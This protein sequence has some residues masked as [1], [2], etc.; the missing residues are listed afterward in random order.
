MK[1]TVKV[2]ATGGGAHMYYD[3]LVSELGVEVRREEE[4][5]CL[6]LGLGFVAHVPEEVFW[7][8]EELVY[9]VSHPSS[10]SSSAIIPPQTIP[11]SELPRPSP[12]PPAYQ[13]TFAPTPSSSDIGG[14]VAPHFPCLLVNIGSGV[15]IVK[16]DEDGGFERVSGTSLGGGTL[17]GLLSLLTDAQ[18]FDGELRL[19]FVSHH[20]ILPRCI[21]PLL[22]LLPSSRPDPLCA[23]R[24]CISPGDFCSTICFHQVLIPLP[25]SRSPT[26]VYSR[27]AEYELTLPRLEML[28]LSELGDNAAVDMLVGDIYGS[29]YSK[30][31]LKSSTI[32]STFGKVFRQG[33][34]KN[35]LKQ[36]DI[37]KSLLYA[38]SNN[39]GHVA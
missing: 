18:S 4:M 20:S 3:L 35:N 8:S 13:V 16:V 34:R 32:A 38:I 33:P 26:H 19:R 14:E 27:S 24:H 21:P 2:M 37:A 15:S 10:S 17:W 28:L 36:E 6:I 23:I 29:D 22:L 1:T 9:K 31:G 7:F 30:I 39:I 12:T 25:S 5:A 11:P